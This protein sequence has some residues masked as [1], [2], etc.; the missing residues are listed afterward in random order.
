[1]VQ[2]F[3]T[4]LNP[5]GYEELQKC[6]LAQSLYDYQLVLVHKTRLYV[7][8]SIGPPL[9]KQLVLLYSGQHYNVITTLSGFYRT[10]YFCWRYI[11]P[12]N[13]EGQ[14]ACETTL[15]TVRPV[16]RTTVPIT[17]KP[18]AKKHPHS[19]DVSLAATPAFASI[20]QSPTREPPSMPRTRVSARNRGRFSG[21]NKLLFG[22]KDQKTHLY[23]SVDY[24]S[25]KE[26]VEAVTHKCFIQVAKSLQEQK[27][28]KK[29]N[30]KRKRGA[31]AGL[32]TLEDNG[33]GM[34]AEGDE[35]K[36]PLHVFFDIKATQDTSSH[37][38]NLLIVETEQDHRPIPFR[39]EESVKHFLEWLDTLTEN[40]T[41]PVTVIAHNFQGYDL[42]FLVD[43]CHR[44]TSAH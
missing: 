44:Q 38:P 29:K 36:P 42:Y 18:H 37:V 2:A 19:A 20:T 1:M 7:V 27:E 33:T 22:L 13:N 26:Y 9:D 28:K 4:N 40:G 31:N 21:C 17:D 6:A 16:S 10:S 43:E 30:K 11:K 15:I 25:C 3:K 32:T 34:D 8:S 23:G 14:H 35:D 5:C 12:Y 41:R 24:I 39:E